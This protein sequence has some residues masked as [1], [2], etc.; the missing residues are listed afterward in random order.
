MDVLSEV[1]LHVVAVSTATEALMLLYAENTPAVL[2]A[3]VHLSAGPDGFELASAARCGWPGI[4]TVLISGDSE[5]A[6]SARGAIDRVLLKPFRGDDLLQ[7][8][9]DL[10]EVAINDR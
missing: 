4:R 2:V 6:Q 9:D 10:T 8:I 7:A 1:G 5:V 3:D